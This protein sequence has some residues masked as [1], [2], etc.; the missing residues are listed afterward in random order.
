MSLG[1]ATIPERPFFR[2]AIAG[3]KR[4]IGPMI[5]A[6]LDG[7]KMAMDRQAAGRV[8]EFMKDRIQTSITTLTQ[9]RQRTGHH[10]SQGIEQST[11]RRRLP[12]ELGR[13]GHRLTQ[14][15]G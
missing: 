15:C 8:G 10:R 12:A 5:R 3:A 1:V 2:Q 14:S 6:S 9:P 4:S 13:L 11:D 7:R